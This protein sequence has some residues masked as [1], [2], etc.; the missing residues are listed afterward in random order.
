MSLDGEWQPCTVH[1]GGRYLMTCDGADRI[2]GGM[3]GSPIIDTNGDAIGLVSTGGEND[4]LNPSLD[5]LPAWMLRKLDRTEYHDRPSRRVIV[6][7]LLRIRTGFLGQA[8]IFCSHLRFNFVSH[9]TVGN[10]IMRR[11]FFPASTSTSD[12][13]AV[14]QSARS[15]GSPASSAFPC[16]TRESR[17]ASVRGA[18]DIAAGKESPRARPSGQTRHR[19]QDH[20]HHAVDQFV[21]IALRRGRALSFSNSDPD[22]SALA[23]VNSVSAADF[24]DHCRSSRRCAR[25]F[26]RQAS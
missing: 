11:Q 25:Y 10:G 22:S 21:H 7:R 8:P 12:A 4:N 24:G 2:R 15:S 5:C 17:C 26:D 16:A 18:L 14:T 9:D 20:P 19:W 6:W 3:S 13:L 23:A 1:N